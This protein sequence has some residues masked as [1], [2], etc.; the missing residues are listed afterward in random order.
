MTRA[1]L[2]EYN[3]RLN[4]REDLESDMIEGEEF[5]DMDIEEFPELEEDSGVLGREGAEVLENL[6]DDRIK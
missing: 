1:L 4:N 2:A 3:N 5:N 6:T